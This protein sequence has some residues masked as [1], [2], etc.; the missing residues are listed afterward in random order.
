MK[1]IMVASIFGIILFAA[2]AYT[3]WYLLNQQKMIET[4]TQKV[5]E[6]P[7]ETVEPPPA[8]DQ[9]PDDPEPLEQLPVAL[10]PKTPM[11][12]DAVLD[13]SRSIQ[14]REEKLLKREALVKKN[15]K[16]LQMLFQDLETKHKE[17]VAFE[18]AIDSKLTAARETLDAI[19]LETS[20]RDA[21]RNTMNASAPLNAP[22]DA[23]DDG[24]DPLDEKV[25]AIREWF[26][27]LKAEQA[28]VY[29]TELAN[30]GDLELAARLL[31]TAKQRNIPK[32]LSAIKNKTL[33]MQLMDELMSMKQ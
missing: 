21:Q 32:I 11:T 5:D 22:G 13:L 6:G 4:A 26:S 28:S 9:D 29:L 18:E 19:K 24:P 31:N 1:T 3:S 15:E 23:Q 25:E 14:M 7:L 2:S 8:K 10:R 27:G 16:R 17:L 12:V 30:R 33:E 20:Q